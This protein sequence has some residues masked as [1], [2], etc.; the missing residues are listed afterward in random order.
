MATL[1][2]KKKQKKKQK[3]NNNNK[4]NGNFTDCHSH[5]G[6]S[7]CLPCAFQRVQYI[8]NVCSHRLCL[9]PEHSITS[10]EAPSSTAVTPHPLPQPLT[11]RN[12]LSVSV[13]LPVLDVSH[14][15]NHTLCVLLCLASL[16]EHRVLR[17]HARGGECQGFTPFHD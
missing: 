4:K 6:L 13:H 2:K 12:P 8:H 15:W 14:Q 3:K 9:V 7:A 10:E 1:Q 5:T 17:V 16:T 11:T